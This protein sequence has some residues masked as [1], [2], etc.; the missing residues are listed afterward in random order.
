[1]RIKCRPLDRGS[2]GVPRPPPPEGT[3][4]SEL[5]KQTRVWGL[6]GSGGPVLAIIKKRKR[7]KA[8]YIFIDNSAVDLSVHFSKNRKVLILMFFRGSGMLSLYLLPSG[9]GDLGSSPQPSPGGA[10]GTSAVDL[11]PTFN[12]YSNSI[13]LVQ[14]VWYFRLTPV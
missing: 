9:H 4:G 11:F 12:W 2:K 14:F 5:G 6:G 1:M 8:V 3:Q 10:W 13:C 7:T